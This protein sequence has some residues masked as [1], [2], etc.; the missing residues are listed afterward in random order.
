LPLRLA[1]D[2]A[3]SRQKR[4]TFPLALPFR[5]EFMLPSVVQS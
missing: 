2:I 3:F 5:F 1:L 4:Q